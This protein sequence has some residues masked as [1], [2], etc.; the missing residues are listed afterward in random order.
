V[1]TSVALASGPSPLYG[2]EAPKTSLWRT[3]DYVAEAQRKYPDRII[4]FARIDP[5]TGDAVELLVK[6]ITEWG[7]KGVKIKTN[8]SLLDDSVQI[9]MSKISELGIPVLFHM[10]VEPS[11]S[12]VKYGDPADLEELVV[13]FPKVKFMAAHHAK[14]FEDL[15]TAIILTRPRR[16]YSDIAAWQSDYLRSSWQFILKMRGLMDKIPH[17]IMMGSDWP[18]LKNMP[19]LSHKQWFDAIRNLKVP[20]QFL[21]LGLGMKDFSQKEKDAILGE[22]ARS[23]LG[24]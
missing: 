2:E 23:I 19:G 11:N 7:L 8:A 17:E 15:L 9:V 10:G 18:F 5:L 12:L 14:G 24:I 21:Q 22:N 3:N 16:I 4:G 1:D 20:E 13:K 6:A